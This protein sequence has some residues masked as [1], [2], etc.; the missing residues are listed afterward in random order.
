MSDPEVCSACARLP[1]VLELYTQPRQERAS[2]ALQSVA[3]DAIQ[4]GWSN[5][6]LLTSLGSRFFSW[7]EGWRITAKSSS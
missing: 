2:R 4:K 1:F 7:G 6:S 3:G 5:A